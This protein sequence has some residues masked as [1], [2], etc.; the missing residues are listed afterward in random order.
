[1]KR[2]SERILVTHAGSLTLDM[3]K[4]RGEGSPEDIR[5][6]VA[7]AVRRQVECG[8]DVVNDGEQAKGSWSNYARERLTGLEVREYPRGEAPAGLGRMYSRDIVEFG[9]Y[10]ALN[11]GAR[12]VERL[13][14]GERRSEP[15]TRQV[16]CLTGPLTYV[17][18][19]AVQTDIANLKAALNGIQVEDAALTAV[20]PGTIEHWLHNE[21]YSSDEDF[22]FAIA[23][24][25]HE[26]YKAIT[27]AGIVL[28]LDDPD[29][30][31]AW[32]I[33]PEMSVKQYQDYE[34][35]RVEAINRSLQGI[36][37]EMVR[38]HVCWG[39]GHGPHKYDIPLKEIIH[40]IY[41][42]NTE[43]YSIEASNVRHEHEWTVFRDAP[44]PAG[45]ILI[46]G[47]AGHSSDHI[48]HPELIAQRLVRYAGVVGRENVIAGTDC[49]LGHR[50]GHPDL[51]WAKLEAMAEGARIASKELWDH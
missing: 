16:I 40:L 5:H 35:L 22:L 15:Q 4:P 43:A 39:S 10:F 25:M 2:S 24:A 47:V 29:L 34:E 48:E 41:K 6:D 46:P 27:D 14:A 9:E 20:A 50:V 3:H 1:M 19:A 12:G 26:E 32:Q 31:D 45:K 49:G 18:Q 44:L 21:Y 36:A 38:L 51:A 28:Q 23:D 8:V 17:G 11:L 13:H 37:P 33:H 30:P 42:A 7:E